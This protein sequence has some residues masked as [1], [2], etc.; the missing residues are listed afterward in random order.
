MNRPFVLCYH[1]I[2]PTWSAGLSVTPEAFESQIS[3]LLGRGWRAA[4]FAE[5]VRS[6]PAKTIA[7]TFDDAFSSVKT[8]ALPILRRLGAPATVFAPSDYISRQAPLAWLG[9]D[10]WSDGP[11]A[12]ELTPMSWEDLGELADL[13]WEIGS[14]T[15]SHPLLTRVLDDDR[16]AAE[17]AESRQECAARIGRPVTTI[18][19][20]YGDVDKRVRTQTRQAGYEAAAAL[21]WPSGAP[22]PFMFP[23]IGVYN[24]DSPR[25]FRVKVGRWS[26]MTPAG[27]LI[28]RRAA[29]AD[30]Y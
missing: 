29:H 4:T 26:H 21:G 11:D 9:L 19:Y 22:D 13:G 3:F 18:A 28:A 7:I 24:K 16:L 20:P 5:V 15:R 2:S 23:R 17:L 14:H 8:Y 12:A 30:R 1:A 25:R 6:A 10:H 27:K